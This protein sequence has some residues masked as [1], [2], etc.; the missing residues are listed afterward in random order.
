MGI[1]AIGGYVLRAVN[2]YRYYIALVVMF[3]VAVLV[4]IINLNLKQRQTAFTAS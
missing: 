2:E 1:I 4:Q 3:A